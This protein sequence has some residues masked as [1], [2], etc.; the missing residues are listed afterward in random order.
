[1]AGGSPGQTR[2]TGHGAWSTTNRPAR[3]RLCGPSRL[4][5]PSRARTSRPAPAAAAMTSR[6]GRPV[7]CTGCQEICGRGCLLLLDLAAGIALRVAAAE[8]TGIGAVRGARRLRAGD[9]QQ[10]DLSLGGS[11]LPGRVHARLPGALHDPGDDGHRILP[12]AA[13]L[14]ITVGHAEVAVK[15]LPA[16]PP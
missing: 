16:S 3:P 15:T 6:S 4:R 8:Q 7:P 5:S 12:R 9:V 10:D 1:M 11:M 14:A 2:S 13:R